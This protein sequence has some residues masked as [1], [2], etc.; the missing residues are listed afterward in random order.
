MMKAHEKHMHFQIVTLGLLT[1]L[2][3]REPLIFKDY[4]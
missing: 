1:H 3:V 4:I 2:G